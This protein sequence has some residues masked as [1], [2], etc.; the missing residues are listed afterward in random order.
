MLV[1]GWFGGWLV[2]KWIV[3]RLLDTEVALRM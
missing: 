2:K 3:A 1:S